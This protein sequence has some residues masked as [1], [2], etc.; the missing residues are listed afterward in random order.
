MVRGQSL[1]DEQPKKSESTTTS[2]AGRPKESKRAS[3]AAS[4]QPSTAQPQTDISI[5]LF[6]FVLHTYLNKRLVE[7]SMRPGPIFILHLSCGSQHYVTTPPMPALPT[8]ADGREEMRR[9]ETKKQGENNKQKRE[10]EP[11]TIPLK[12]LL[13][14]ELKLV[15]SRYLIGCHARCG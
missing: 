11:L 1:L 14:P 5:V 7:T 4:N 10:I 6:C 12:I 8:A 15:C 2:R 3:Q 9:G 13:P